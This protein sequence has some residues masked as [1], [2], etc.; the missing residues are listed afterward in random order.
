M[1]TVKSKDTL[2]LVGDL[3]VEVFLLLFEVGQP[4]HEGV[5]R[6]ALFNGV[7]Y[8]VDSFL[9]LGSFTGQG[10]ELGVLCDLGFCLAYGYIGNLFNQVVG[11]HFH[12]V[13]RYPCL[14]KLLFQRLHTAITVSFS[15][16]AFV[17]IVY[18]SRVTCAGLPIHCLTAM[19]TKELP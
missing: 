18:L 19:T 16:V 7:G 10:G 14:Y 3:P 1:V 17:V 6:Y 12:S 2:F 8:V 11:E 9:Y 4:V 15:T 5:G 13:L